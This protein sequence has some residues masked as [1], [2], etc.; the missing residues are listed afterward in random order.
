MPLGYRLK[1]STKQ[2]IREYNLGKKHSAETRLKMSLAQK[3]KPNSGQFKKGIHISPFTQFKKGIKPWNTGTKGAFKHTDEEKRKIGEAAKG[4]QYR[5]GKKIS[6]DHKKSIGNAAKG[7]KWNV[8]RKATEEAKKKM[9]IAQQLR[10]AEGRSPL[11]IDGRTNKIGYRNFINR[12]RQIRK[13]GN[14]GSHVQ[15]EWENLKAQ[16]NWTCPCCKR[17]EPNIKLTQDHIIPLFKGGSDNIENIQP[18]CQK[19]NSAKYIKIIKF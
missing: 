13:I 7:N 11:W 10:V 12:R 5:V 17:S 15:A 14:G 18:L 9:R 16:Y 19:C 1:E 4:N 8:G 6:E 3:A 2:K